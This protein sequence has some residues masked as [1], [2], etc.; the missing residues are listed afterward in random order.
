MG[1]FIIQIKLKIFFFSE[2]NSA[3]QREKE[4]RLSKINFHILFS[5]N[6]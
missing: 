6:D 4:K 3:K 2:N 5:K 1:P